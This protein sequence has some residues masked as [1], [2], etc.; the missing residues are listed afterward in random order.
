M[1]IPNFFFPHVMFSPKTPTYYVIGP[2]NLNVAKSS[3]LIWA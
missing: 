3:F 2:N 1:G